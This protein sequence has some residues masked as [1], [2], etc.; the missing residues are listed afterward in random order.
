[1]Q[2][3]ADILSGD[4]VGFDELEINFNS[5]KNLMEIDELYAIGPSLSILM[6]GYV[7]N[8]SGQKTQEDDYSLSILVAVVERVKGLFKVKQRLKPP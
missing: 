7:E 6:N 8:K 1:M 4:G 2:G 3:I 5:K